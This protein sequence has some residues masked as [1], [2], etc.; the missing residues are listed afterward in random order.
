M[1]GLS[2]GE[3]TLSKQE[4][5]QSASVF[6]HIAN[7]HKQFNKEMTQVKKNV[8]IRMNND[9]KMYVNVLSRRYV[10]RNI[11]CIRINWDYYEKEHYLIVSR[12][13]EPR[14]TEIAT[15]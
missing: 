3:L 4:H 7:L 15:L 10:D 6:N 12:N 9:R 13:N 5:Q 2:V 8:E 1:L 11:T 14:V